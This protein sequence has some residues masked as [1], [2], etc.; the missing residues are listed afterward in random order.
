[1]F[2]RDFFDYFSLDD[3]RIYFNLADVSGKG[4]NAALLMA[5]ASSLFRCL[6]KRV[7]DP[8]QLLAQINVEICETSTRGMFVT[9]IAGLYDPG[10]GRL[11]LVNAGH[12]PGLLL[13][14]DGALSALEAQ[15]P[16]LGVD[17]GC[18]FPEVDVPLDGG[19]LYLFSD[20]VT[21][22]HTAEGEE[23]GVRGLL[24]MI[25]EQGNQLPGERLESIVTR[26]T[27]TALPLRDDITM[28]LLEEHV[29]TAAGH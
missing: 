14:K 22:G 4:V 29:G 6:G 7:H 26:F 27:S 1:M 20:G 5:K 21:E 10:S 13:R 18:A 28:L 17:P 9:M 2:P 3:G 23:L 15:A 25:A 8:G 11:R 16:P 24:G 12:P 19:S